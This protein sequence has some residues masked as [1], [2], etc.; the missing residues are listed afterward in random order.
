MNTSGINAP[1]NQATGINVCL[2]GSM[3]RAINAPGM[4]P[5]GMI[6]PEMNPHQIDDNDDD[7]L[8]MMQHPGVVYYTCSLYIYIYIYIYWHCYRRALSQLAVGSTPPMSNADTTVW[9]WELDGVPTTIMYSQA[10]NEVWCNGYILETAVWAYLCSF[11]EIIIIHTSSKGLAST[12][13][14]NYS[15]LMAHFVNSQV[16]EIFYRLT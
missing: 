13:D 10:R 6:A 3:A 4:K 15:N 8:M 16:I 1:W 14:I 12:A 11:K 9:Y 5:S 7:A 2:M